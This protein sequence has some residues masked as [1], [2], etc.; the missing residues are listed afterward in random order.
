MVRRA[1]PVKC[2]DVGPAQNDTFGEGLYRSQPGFRLLQAKRVEGGMD[3]RMGLP[4]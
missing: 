4:E 2:N 3:C 1:K